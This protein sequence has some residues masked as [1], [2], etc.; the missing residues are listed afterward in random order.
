MT[1]QQGK[2]QVWSELWYMQSGWQLTDDLIKTAVDPVKWTT[3]TGV[4]LPLPRLS[5]PQANP[6]PQ[7][8]VTSTAQSVPSQQNVAAAEP[9]LRSTPNQLD[10]AY[11]QPSQQHNAP[12][13]QQQQQGHAQQP[14]HAAQQQLGGLSL[15]DADDYAAAQ[16]AWQQHQQQRQQ[17]PT[18]QQQQQQSKQPG[19]SWQQPVQPAWQQQ[20]Q[21]QQNLLPGGGQEVPKANAAADVA[22]LGLSTPPATIAGTANAVDT[23]ATGLYIRAPKLQAS[24]SAGSASAR[25]QIEMEPPVCFEARLPPLHP[26]VSARL[27][28]LGA[29]QGSLFAGPS[30]KGGLLQWARPEANMR[31]PLVPGAPDIGYGCVEPVWCRVCMSV[32]RVLVTLPACDCLCILP[33]RMMLAS[34]PKAFCCGGTGQQR[35]CD[36]VS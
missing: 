30:A 31:R 8:T 13:G 29:G 10:D 26:K 34:L 15:L 28:F 6:M 2:H 25:Q 18:Q 11:A 22:S 14:M 23:P 36:H 35:T 4:P 33:R 5:A 24:G 19:L 12:A 16:Q 7:Q 21:Q 27:K 17:P 3:V 1:S 9:M 20:Q 32:S